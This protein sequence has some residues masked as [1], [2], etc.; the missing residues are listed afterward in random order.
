MVSL[1]H[2][3]AIIPEKD[4]SSPLF[5]SVSYGVV[6]RCE[7]IFGSP[8]MDCRGTGIC[9]IISTEERTDIGGACART[10]A[11][12]ASRRDDSGM[13]IFFSKDQ[14]SDE[15]FSRHFPEN[16]LSMDEPCPV[17]EFIRTG[18]KTDIQRLSAGSYPLQTDGAYVFITVA[19]NAC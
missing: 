1:P 2:L 11:Y 18:L 8:S 19:A 17:P 12:I 6:I 9:K 3:N 15:V 10:P 7:I 13:L 4:I 16:I 14:L 5:R